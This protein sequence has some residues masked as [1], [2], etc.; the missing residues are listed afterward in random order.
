MEILIFNTKGGVGKTTLTIAMADV[1]EGQIVEWDLQ[2][3]ISNCFKL[4]GRHQPVQLKDATAKYIIHDTP[5]YNSDVLPSLIKRADTIIIPVRMSATDLVACTTAID[6]LRTLQATDRAKIVFNGVRKPYTN[7]YREFKRA[8]AK[9]YNDV[10]K[11]DTEITNL[12]AFQRIM[13]QP[14]G[15]NAKQLII[16]LLQELNIY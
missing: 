12:V 8:F 5:P 3:T 2:G 15:G 4:T 9:N 11:A 6:L 10:V 13:Q 14:I 7:T 1:L 16:Q